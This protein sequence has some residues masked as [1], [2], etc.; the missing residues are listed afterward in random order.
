MTNEPSP[1]KK[2]GL[3]VSFDEPAAVGDTPSDAAALEEEEKVGRFTIANLNNSRVAREDSAHA[4]KSYVLP[5]PSF[6][7]CGARAAEHSLPYVT[8][9]SDP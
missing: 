9:I 1:T 2:S 3:S 7:M 6:W 8:G 4:P 5:S